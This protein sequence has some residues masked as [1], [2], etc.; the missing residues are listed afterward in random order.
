MHFLY[1][2]AEIDLTYLPFLRC[3]VRL[4][5]N[6]WVVCSIFVHANR[7]YSFLFCIFENGKLV[8]FLF[9][10]ML[11]TSCHCFWNCFFN[12][13]TVAFHVLSMTFWLWIHL[14]SL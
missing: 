14:S 13:R 5:C 3:A 10:A 1:S 9:L 7:S 2:L 12:Y 4:H 11:L 6:F 8:I